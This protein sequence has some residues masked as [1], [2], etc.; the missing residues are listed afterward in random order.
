MTTFTSLVDEVLLTLY[1]YGL[2]QPKAATLRTA[3]S[4][5]DLT[6]T[7][8]TVE[9]FAQGLAEIEGELVFIE[10][11][12]EDS[13]TVTCS[14]DGRG[15]YGTTAVAHDAGKRLEY[16][17]PWPRQRVKAALNET[18]L[19]VYPT[20]WG[21]GTTSF[22]FSPAVATYTLPDEVD[23]VLQVTSTV[24]GPSGN[25]EPITHYSF[26]SS[27]PTG[28][29]T[30]TINRGGTPGRDITVVYRKEPTELAEGANFTDSGLRE[31]ARLA[32]KLG[33]V[34][35]LLAYA[36]VARL[37]TDS[38]ESEAYNEKNPIGT[39]TRISLQVYQ[40]FQA[41]LDAERRRLLKITPTRLTVSR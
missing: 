29:N 35:N 2:K 25:N 3:V 14:P 18:L 27:D 36:D 12:D 41:E 26:N 38:A 13:S 7:L 24:Y 5:T 11:V 15:Y 34:S 1:G 39:A 37:G 19:T 22:A 20:I 21:V 32:V 33:A 10:T 4:A 16:L 30:I 28:N 31:S 40:R 17:P 6:F 9:G 23:G 8:S